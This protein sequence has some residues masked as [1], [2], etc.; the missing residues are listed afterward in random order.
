MDGRIGNRQKKVFPIQLVLQ[1]FPLPYMDLATHQLI[2]GLQYG[3]HG[4][5]GNYIRKE[6]AFFIEFDCHDKSPAVVVNQGGLYDGL[7]FYSQGSWDP[8]KNSLY[9][10]PTI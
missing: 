7:M 4:N 1:T 8:L 3:M 2:G 5:L 10:R 9:P 6:F